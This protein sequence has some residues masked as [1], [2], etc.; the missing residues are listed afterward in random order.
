MQPEHQ[1]HAKQQHSPHPKESSLWVMFWP[2]AQSCKIYLEY[3]FNYSEFMLQWEHYCLFLFSIHKKPCSSLYCICSTWTY[4][5]FF[6]RWGHVLE[7]DLL[8]CWL[9]GKSCF[10]ICLL[11]SAFEGDETVTDGCWLN[12]LV[13]SLCFI[14]SHALNRAERW[15]RDEG[16][17]E[18]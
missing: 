8:F 12:K 3:I 11:T 16:V 5:L 2:E 9:L 18:K 15:Y 13:F 10:Q 4:M 1:S 7:I 6:F 17:D 14:Y